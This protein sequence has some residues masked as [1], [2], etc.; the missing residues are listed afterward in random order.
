LPLCT[1]RKNF[2]S[3]VIRKCWYDGSAWIVSSTHLPPPVMIEHCVSVVEA[4]ENAE[5]H[6]LLD[7]V[8]PSE[9]TA[10]RSNRVDYAN[11]INNLWKYCPKAFD[12]G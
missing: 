9:A 8:P 3:S 4:H 12:R 7:V 10:A 5:K 2:F 1:Q 6:E 11:A